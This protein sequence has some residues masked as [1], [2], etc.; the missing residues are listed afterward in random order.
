[1]D[2]LSDQSSKTS[3]TQ[4]LGILA[5][6][7]LFAVILRG[8]DYPIGN[9]VYHVP[10]VLDYAGT[11]EGPQDEFH[12]SLSRYVSLLW[13]AMS[14]IATDE[15]VYWLFLG[16]H[17][18]TRLLTI[19]LIWRLAVF[20]T[21]NGMIS[22]LL[23]SCLLFLSTSS[24]YSPVGATEMLGKGY[25][26]HSLA[27]IPAVLLSWLLLYRRRFSLSALIA[28]LSFNLNAFMGVWAAVVVGVGTMAS[29]PGQAR[30]R[31]VF[32]M[33]GLFVLAAFP[34]IAWILV[35]ITEVKPHEPFSYLQY[36]REY[37]PYH[38]FLDADWERTL[39]FAVSVGLGFAVFNH[40]S[41]SWSHENRTAVRS[42]LL[43][44]FGILV[45]GGLIPYLIDVRLLV[46]LFPLRM[47]V[48]WIIYVWMLLLVWCLQ[49]WKEDDPRERAL[50][51]I[52]L[53]SVANGNLVLLAEVLALSAV[54]KEGAG[55]RQRIAG[56]AVVALA[57][58][59]IYFEEVPSLIQV[60]GRGAMVVCLAQTFV[61]TVALRGTS[62]YLRDAMLLLAGGL[63][64]AIHPGDSST[65]LI[66]VGLLY[67]VVVMGVTLRERPRLV[68]GSVVVSSLLAGALMGVAWI[69]LV[70]LLLAM[71]LAATLLPTLRGENPER[72]SHTILVWTACV[73]FAILSVLQFVR[74]GSLAEHPTYIQ[75]LTEASLWARKHTDPNTVFLAV[76]VT[77]FTVQSRRPVWTDWKYGSMVMWAPEM[78]APWKGRYDEIAKIQTVDDALAVARTHGL[79]YI[80]FDSDVSAGDAPASCIAFE[81]GRYWILRASCVQIERSKPN[82]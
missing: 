66:A 41:V 68:V 48:F 80:V 19:G 17:F 65:L 49:A 53:F 74:R 64:G 60:G 30:A 12:L 43:A 37:F 45:F 70:L 24:S 57:V 35:A 29:P 4:A 25:F 62:S 69:S 14:L 15:N 46:N 13:P 32:S 7:T 21:G 33:A 36:M 42:T 6:A 81:N 11:P 3:A 38:T 82:F 47:S 51:L 75:E 55:R 52:G 76:G 27:V 31:T 71:P 39:T 22:A 2:P 78:Y 28:G 16:G 44:L 50:S 18:L 5:A 67:I 59:H 1:M 79:E 34:T 40:V 72:R 26:T 10:V 9:N 63:S 77:N 58:I 20:L 56:A 61:I 23:A 8:F 54:G 73:G